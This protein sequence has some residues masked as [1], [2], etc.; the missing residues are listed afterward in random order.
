MNIKF[1][2]LYRDSSNY[3]QY[4]EVVFAN[5]NE[6]PLEQI[7]RIIISNLIDGSWFIAK[8]WYLPD[9]HFKEYDWDY[10]I[11]H[12]WYEFSSIE[13]TSDT[14]TAQQSIEDF[15]ERIKVSKIPLV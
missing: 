12:D 8:D 7:K 6:L 11:D 10:E 9:M 4:N 15:I 5:S 13:E 14:P 1:A 2:Y 3:K